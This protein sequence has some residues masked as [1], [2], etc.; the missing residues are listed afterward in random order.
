MGGRERGERVE[1]GVVMFTKRSGFSTKLFSIL[2]KN[3]SL[4]KLKIGRRENKYIF[5]L[6]VGHGIGGGGKL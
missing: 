1:R 4:N 2:P 5:L 6:I 3:R